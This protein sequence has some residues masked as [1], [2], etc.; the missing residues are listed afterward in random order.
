MP[1]SK[2]QKFHSTLLVFFFVWT[3]F[4]VQK[5]WY[6]S[7]HQDKVFLTMILNF[8]TNLLRSLW[9]HM[10]CTSKYTRQ[11]K[12]LLPINN[13]GHLPYCHDPPDYFRHNLRESHGMHA[14]HYSQITY[15]FSP[16]GVNIHSRW[17]NNFR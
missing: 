15:W 13:M 12:I 10:K 3:C 1:H 2:S 5:I 6:F 9:F 7:F 17:Q 14:Q 8:S 4:T 16:S 11:K